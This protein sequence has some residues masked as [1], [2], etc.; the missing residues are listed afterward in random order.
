LSNAPNDNK[1]AWFLSNE[2]AMKSRDR[3]NKRLGEKRLLA[4]AVF[5]PGQPQW[6]DELEKAI[7]LGP[8]AWK[9][10][11]LGDPGGTSRYPWRLDD[12]K[13]VYPAFEKMEKAGVRNI[14][15]HKGLLPSGFKQK[16]TKEQIDYAHVGDV[17]KAAKDWPRL[18]FIIYHSGIQKVL[19]GPEDAREFRKTGQIE[20]VTHLAEIPDK[21]GVEN[22]YGEIGATFAGTC[23]AHPELCA[24][25]LGTLIRGLGDDH[26]CWGTDS[27][28]FGSPQWQIE[29]MRRIEIPETMQKHYGFK[30]LGSA[31][32]S[33]KRAIFGMNSARL[34]G[35]SLPGTLP[36]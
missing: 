35:L 18:N 19:P 9:G 30:P 23:I 24:G 32:G 28:W 12:E 1:Q 16:F 4:H 11:T 3:V 14:C 31:D 7:A 22:V 13:L 2:Q 6:M 10:Y 20:W 26:V 17:G 27:I 34:Y 15:I 33:V 29:A 36:A 25:V 21:Y 8:D 5:T